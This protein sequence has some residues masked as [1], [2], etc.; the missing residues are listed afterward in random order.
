MKIEL[1]HNSRDTIKKKKSRNYQSKEFAIAVSNLKEEVFIVY[2]FSL[3]ILD[4]NIYL[5]PRVQIAFFLANKALIDVLSL[6]TNYTNIF[7]SELIV[8]LPEYIKINNR[9]IFMEKGR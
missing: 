7:L 2:I 1:I 8:K 9:L 5:S 3:A 6:Y 4:I